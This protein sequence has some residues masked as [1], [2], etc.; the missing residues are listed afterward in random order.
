MA[1]KEDVYLLKALTTRPFPRDYEDLLTLQQT[2]LNWNAV[3]AEYESQVKNTPLEQNLAT[4]MSYLKKQGITNP[5]VKT[6][7]KRV[8]ND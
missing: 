2:G 6:I 8:K 5:L 1:S 7:D 4:K 3:T